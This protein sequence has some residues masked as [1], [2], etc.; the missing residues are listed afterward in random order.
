MCSRINTHPYHERASTFS[1][2]FS[3][4]NFYNYSKSKKVVANR[5]YSGNDS[6][7]LMEKGQVAVKY[8]Q[9]HLGGSPRCS[10]KKCKFFKEKNKIIIFSKEHPPGIKCTFL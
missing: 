1:S 3:I 6:L 8:G 5:C 9:D 4:A 7:Y 2:L 10:S